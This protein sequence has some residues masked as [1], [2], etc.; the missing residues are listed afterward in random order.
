LKRVLLAQHEVEVPAGVHDINCS[1]LEQ[2]ELSLLDL[3]FGRN[4]HFEVMPEEFCCV[5]KLFS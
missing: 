1:A 2:A 5:S 4:S 3:L